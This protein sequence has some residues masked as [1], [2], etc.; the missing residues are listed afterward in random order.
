[1]PGWWRPLSRVPSE[2][3]KCRICVLGFC[4]DDQQTI[5]L[6]V[7]GERDVLVA[8][9]PAGGVLNARKIGEQNPILPGGRPVAA[10]VDLAKRPHARAPKQSANHRGRYS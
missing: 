9:R 8:E 2:P 4:A 1:M 5:G 6:A 7:D 3:G 10:G